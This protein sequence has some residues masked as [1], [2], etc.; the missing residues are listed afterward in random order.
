MT[1]QT[2]HNVCPECGGKGHAR[3]A[4]T[5]FEDAVRIVYDCEDCSVMWEVEFVSPS[6]VDTYP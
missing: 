3:G 4:N 2:D 1:N 6:V 5:A